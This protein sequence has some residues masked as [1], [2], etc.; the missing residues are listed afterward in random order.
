MD[1]ICAE[2]VESAE[3]LDELAEVVDEPDEIVHDQHH[4]DHHTV[5]EREIVNNFNFTSNVGIVNIA[6]HV[7]RDETNETCHI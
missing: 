5:N 2:A 3:F 4:H 6:E 7:A 1:N